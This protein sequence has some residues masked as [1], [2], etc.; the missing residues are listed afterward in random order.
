MDERKL[1]FRVGATV[2]AAVLITCI[3]VALFGNVPPP[4]R[5]KTTI[6]VRFAE[7]PGAAPTPPCARAAFSSAA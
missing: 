7:A 4:F 3:L 2:V 6:C 1:Q 5:R